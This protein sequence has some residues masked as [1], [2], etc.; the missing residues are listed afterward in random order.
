VDVTDDG[1]ATLTQ[2]AGRV[3]CRWLGPARE[4]DDGPDANGPE[5]PSEHRPATDHLAPPGALP[6]EA[7]VTLGASRLRVRRH[8]DGTGERAVLTARPG[9]PWRRSLQ[10]APRALPAWEPAP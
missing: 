2:L 4:G 3:P 5:N 1:R 8:V 9:D 7:V 6:S 10:R